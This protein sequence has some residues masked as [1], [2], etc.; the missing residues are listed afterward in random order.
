MSGNTDRWNKEL[1]VQFI[2]LYRERPCLWQI[3][4]TTYTNKN[5]KNEAYRE[6]VNLIKPTILGAN[7]KLVKSKIQNMRGAFRKEKRKVD[8]EMKSSS[9]A[10][11]E[12]IYEPSLW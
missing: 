12:T 9:G 10:A 11:A 7:E 4:H 6:L 8:H 3:K 1:T 5:L 2:E